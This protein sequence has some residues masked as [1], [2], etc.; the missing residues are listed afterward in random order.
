MKT[1][2]IEQQ[3]GLPSPLRNYAVS[4]ALAIHCKNLAETSI[5]A[6]MEDP[7]RYRQFTI[8]AA[9]LCLDYSRHRITTESLSD[10]IELAREAR[11]EECREA[12]FNG[13]TIN[14]SEQRAVLHTALRNRS[15]RPVLVD[16]ADVMPAIRDTLE[17]MRA[18]CQRIHSGEWTGYTGKAIK[19]IVSIGIGGSFL[20]VKTALDGLRPF[21]REELTAHYV[22][23]VDPADL[24]ATLKVIDPETTLFIVASKSFSTLETR[25]NAEASKA[26]MLEQG[27]P[28]QDSHRH[29]VAVSN[30]IDKATQFGIAPDNILPL[31][32]WVGGRYSLW[33]AIGLMIPLMTSFT[34]FERLLHGAYSMDEHFRIAPL[35][36]NM[37][38][39]MA[40][41]GIWYSNYFGAQSHAVLTYASDLEAFPAHL[42]QMDM[43]SNGKRVTTDGQPVSW[44]TGPVIWGGVGTNGQHAYHQLLHQGT[45]LIPVDIIVPMISQSPIGEQQDWLFAHALAQSQALALGCS[46][47][48]IR[49]ELTKEGASQ[50]MIDTLAPQKA[51]PGNKPASLLVMESLTPEALGALIALYEH[52][53]FVQGV[54]WGINSFDQFGVELG[55]VLGNQIFEQLNDNQPCGSEHPALNQWI[56]RYRRVHNRNNDNR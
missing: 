30:N 18:L 27:M 55:K 22:V 28:E 31:W 36:Q 26:W 45:R 47:E 29:F 52:K 20:G 7:E 38:V 17:R 23:N 15:Q 43:E 56:Q 40:L 51:I 12:M 16:G 44:Q 3:P 9:G 1:P 19:H 21:Q 6:L 54:I 25:V 32:D 13:S 8:E 46:E 14:T 53:V 33:S 37:S 41:M 35:E 42:Q 5:A 34:V 11:L 39:I 10:L 4:P 24:T 49:D 50:E 48:T 2:S